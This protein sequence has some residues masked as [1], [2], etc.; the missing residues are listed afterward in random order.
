[1]GTSLTACRQASASS[2]S[3]DGDSDEDLDS[4]DDEAGGFSIMDQKVRATR[5]LPNA[6][7]NFGPP[8]NFWCFGYEA[9]NKEIKDAARSSNY[10]NVLS[11]VATRLS[12]RAAR[13]IH[14]RKRKRATTDRP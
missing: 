1:M 3:R 13:A 7:C 11:T 4:S 9:K 10:K 12:Y 2:G 5:L 8:R 6:P 14:K